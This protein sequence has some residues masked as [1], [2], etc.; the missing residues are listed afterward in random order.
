M[1]RV[2]RRRARFSGPRRSEASRYERL[3]E[4]IFL[5]HYRKGTT[6]VS[7]RREDIEAAATALGIDL[8]KNIG[9]LVYSFRY[10]ATLPESIRS[11]ASR[12]QEWVI[13]PAG[14]SLYRFVLTSLARLVPNE[15]LAE[16]KIPDSTPGVIAKYALTDEQA[17]LAK[18]R[19]N[20]LVDI[21]TGITCYSLQSHLRTTVSALGQVETDEVYIGVDR[22]GVHYAFPIQVK[23]GGDALSVV[24]VRQDLEMCR[25]KWPTL[26]CR[27]IAAQFMA[28]DLIAMFELE[29]DREHIAAIAAER[30]Y[31]L[32]DPEKI[33]PQELEA[34]RRRTD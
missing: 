15:Q 6:E 27:P 34:Y 32:V 22:K 4:H 11:K 16:T 19:Y 18:V 21:F 29:G 13:L 28:H 2:S 14:K 20:R 33:T 26:I 23:R 8:P 9:D 12:G 5:R 10:R 1:A 25:E 3:L 24:Q 17:L 30:H 31:R 7:F